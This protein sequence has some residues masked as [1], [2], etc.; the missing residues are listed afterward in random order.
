MPGPKTLST[1]TKGSEP[2]LLMNTVNGVV[3]VPS[4]PSTWP[5]VFCPAT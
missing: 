2:V 3:E 1:D 5:A 4:P